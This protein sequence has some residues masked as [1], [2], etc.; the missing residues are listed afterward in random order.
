M[1]GLSRTPGKRV[2]VHSLTRVR[3]PPSLPHSVVAPIPQEVLM[4]T[5]APRG[6]V[7]LLALLASVL[8]IGVAAV[9]WNTATAISGSSSLQ[10]PYRFTV[11]ARYTFGRRGSLRVWNISKS[12]NVEWTFK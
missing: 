5:R 4:A 11:C 7:L 6:V 2:Q 10:Y 1:S 12:K 9:T 3:I 8:V